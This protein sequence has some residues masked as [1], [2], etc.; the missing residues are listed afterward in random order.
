[1][2][3][4][5][6][7]L[8]A[9]G[10][11]R[12]KVY[13][14]ELSADAKLVSRAQEAGYKAL[15]SSGARGLTISR[16][17]R[18]ME[19]YY[20]MTAA[21][22]VRIAVSL[23]RLAED[24]AAEIVGGTGFAIL[25]DERGSPLFF[26]RERLA[27]ASEV[28]GWRIVE[29]ALKSK[30]VGSSEFTDRTGRAF[31]GAYAPVAATGG[32]VVILQPRD[33]AYLAAAEMRRSSLMALAVV[34]ILALLT[35]TYTARKMTAPLLALTRGAEAVAK[36]DLKAS[37]A[38]A[39]RDEIQD[40]AETFNRMVHQLR[41]YAELQ[42]DRLV[43]EQRKTGAIL[44]SIDE[45]ILLAD[46]QRRIQLVNRRAVELL[47]LDS[48]AVLDNQPLSTIL[49]GSPLKDAMLKASAQTVAGA[50]TEIGLSSQK[51]AKHLRITALPVTSPATGAAMGTL[52]AVRDVTLEKELDKMKESFLQNVT[53]D[54]RNPLGSAVGFMEALLKDVGGPLTPRQRGM[55]SSIHRSSQRLMGMI[56]N[57]LDIGK[58]ESGKIRL[59]LH[60][61]VLA[62]VAG[63]SLSILESLSLHKKITV[64]SDIP[65]DL[66]LRADADLVERALTNLIGN[67]IKFT[68]AD[69]RIQI[70]AA[71]Q[72]EFVR[73]CVADSGDGVPESY[74]EK[75]F[76]KFEQVGGQQRKGGTGL[77]LT[78]TKAFV[79]AH[80]GRI[81]VESEVGKG[82]Q[83][84]FTLSKSLAS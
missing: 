50:F 21:A 28:P 84:Y 29:A 49:E 62:E 36:G 80:G 12:L 37:V 79:Q 53:H 67:A 27:D 76:E 43:S 41:G 45:G 65:A 59:N 83:F 13:N 35:A 51:G 10:H 78:I 26:A 47:G 5:I 16:E 20:P 81:W 56:N 4:E 31:V 38:I 64:T 7:V 71:D 61:V 15:L 42:V 63:R 55:I 22:R 8:N 70:S 24:V 44:F 77:G 40:L 6:S 3:I 2:I 34:L 68:P 9:Q 60:P 39:S 14:P 75:I 32:A 11:E 46:E 69:G 25:I 52:L 17:L 54:L 58:M 66:N 74:R 18:T 19:L 73:V 48:R 57:I 82:S 72:G 33:E 23:R 1:D 30:S